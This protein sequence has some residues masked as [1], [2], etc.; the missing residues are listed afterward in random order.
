MKVG[1]ALAWARETIASDSPRSDAECLLADSLAQSRTWLKTW[2]EKE[3]SAAQEKRFCERVNR[4]A[5][6]E[7]VAYILGHR[8]FWSLQLKTTDCTLIPRP[9]TELLVELALQFLQSSCAAKAA[10]VLDLGTGTGAI[11]LSIAAERP[12]D[13]VLATDFAGDIVALARENARLNQIENIE[14]LQ[15]DWFAALSA[16]KHRFD[17]IVSNPPYVAPGDLHLAEG[18]LRFEPRSALVA[19]DHGFAELVQ[20]AAEAPH[21]LKSGGGLM[22][23]HGFAQ[24]DRMKDILQQAGYAEIRTE[25]DLAGLQRITC[26]VKP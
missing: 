26:G 10:S 14:I 2:P 5:N 3:L 23:E 4:R 1:Q 20:I 25:K 9:E 19:G 16:K 11:A 18:D 21:F 6:G 22:V 12:Q 15:S 8:A 17:L 7:P 24:G 13:L